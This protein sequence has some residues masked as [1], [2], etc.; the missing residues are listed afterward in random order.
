MKTLMS[1]F[2]FFLTVPDLSRKGMPLSNKNFP[3]LLICMLALAGCL[4]KSQEPDLP[5]LVVPSFKLEWGS[6]GLPPEN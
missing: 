6:S 4:I 5:P 3:I 2:R 1:S